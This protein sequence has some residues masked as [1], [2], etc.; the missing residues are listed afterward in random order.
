[1]FEGVFLAYFSFADITKISENRTK[2][3]K[4]IL[5]NSNIKKNKQKIRNKKKPQEKKAIG[6]D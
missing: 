4:N 1:M 3:N 6:D 2:P 5:L